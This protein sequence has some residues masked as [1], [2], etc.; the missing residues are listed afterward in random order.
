[1]KDSMSIQEIEQRVRDVERGQ[2]IHGEHIATITANAAEQMEEIR[3][4]SSNVSK[5][6]TNLEIVIARHTDLRA[7]QCAAPALCL[8]LDTRITS[9]EETRSE[10]R[11]GWKMITVIGGII[12]SVS[13]AV[14]GFIG[15]LAANW[16][17]VGKAAAEEAIKQ[18]QN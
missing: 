6:N 11:G 7:V 17:G 14:G 12:V 15:W 16:H 3:R 4:I 1:M 13:G 8:K 18:A 9:L 10:Q 5:M 2:A